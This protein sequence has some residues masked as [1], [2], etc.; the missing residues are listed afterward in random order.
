M[1]VTIYFDDREPIKWSV[2]ESLGNLPLE[3]RKKRS[4]ETPPPYS[5]TPGTQKCYKSRIREPQ[6]FLGNGGEIIIL[7]DGSIWKE[8][9]HQYL[10]LYEYYHSVI[11]R[12][13]TGKMILK[14]HVFQIVPVR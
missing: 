4:T 5:P 11:V 1:W 13:S 2:E 9:S 10:Y 8:V 14:S 12:P 7:D 3:Q 6:P